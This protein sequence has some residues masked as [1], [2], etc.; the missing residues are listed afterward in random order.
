M[1]LSFMV[2]GASDVEPRTQMPRLRSLDGYCRIFHYKHTLRCISVNATYIN[3]STVKRPRIDIPI[4]PSPVFSCQ[5]RS[6][7]HKS[8]L[9]YGQAITILNLVT[10]PLCNAQSTLH[11]A[12]KKGDDWESIFRH[13]KKTARKMRSNQSYRFTAHTIICVCHTWVGEAKKLWLLSS[14]DECCWEP[15]QTFLLLWLW[16]FFSN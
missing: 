12:A 15:S 3:C 8:T 6:Y 16:F 7:S 4:M 13:G 9:H 14:G 5:Q 2:G 11:D 10:H 1:M